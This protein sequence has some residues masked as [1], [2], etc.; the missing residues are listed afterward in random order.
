M[1]LSLFS[2]TCVWLRRVVLYVWGVVYRARR[3]RPSW[4]HRPAES[5]PPPP[6]G[7]AASTPR[8]QLTNTH[9]RINQ[10]YTAGGQRKER[11]HGPLTLVRD[12]AAPE[13]HDHNLLAHGTLHH[14]PRAVTD[15]RSNCKPTHRNSD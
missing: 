5:G 7:P 11:Q 12:G 6:T 15:S 1:L 14:Q 10:L 4:P 3:R 8:T 9:V 2:V 13:L